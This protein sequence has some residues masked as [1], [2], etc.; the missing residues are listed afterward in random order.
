LRF[1]VTDRAQVAAA[2]EVVVERHGGLDILVNNVGVRDRRGALEFD[3]DSFARLID[4]DLV[5]VFDLSR[6]A[7]EL[8]VERGEGR[9]IN[10]TSIAATIANP[11]D[12]AYTAAKGGL[13][14]LTRAMAAELGPYGITVNAVA[15][16]VFATET[17]AEALGNPEVQARLQSRI[18]LGR[19]GR[20]GEIAGAVVFL[21]SPA[22]SFVTGHVL[23]VDGGHSARM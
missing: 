1:D 18:S 6:R 5:A 10:I 3:T 12:A 21:A 15:P 23:V 22:A 9:I 20:P 2:F 13:D 4:A 16:G 8:M 14:A 17:N 7:A 19:W 11:R